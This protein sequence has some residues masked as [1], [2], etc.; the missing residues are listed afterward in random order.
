[1][2]NSCSAHPSTHHGD[3]QNDIVATVQV[4]SHAE[5]GTLWKPFSSTNY[6]IFGHA[7]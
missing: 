1:M 2:K 4:C 5:I 3:G 7:N 6:G